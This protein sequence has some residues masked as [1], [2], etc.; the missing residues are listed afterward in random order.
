MARVA[1]AG[2]DAGSGSGSGS[3]AGADAGADAG[4]D[5]VNCGAG[6]SVSTCYC[7]GDEHDFFLPFCEGRGATLLGLDFSFS[8]ATSQKI[9]PRVINSF[10]YK[11][12]EITK[13]VFLGNSL[14]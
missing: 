5:V 6:A 11:D 10:G 9:F 8:F 3:G 2:S 12:T 14:T 4:S 7:A 13:Y 1:G